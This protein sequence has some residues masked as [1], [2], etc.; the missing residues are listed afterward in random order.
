[1][2]A[3]KPA[4][5]TTSDPTLKPHSRG[6]FRVRDVSI[7]D[8]VLRFRRDSPGFSQR[9]AGTFADRGDTILGRWELC[10][11]EVHWN[12]DLEITYRRGHLLLAVAAELDQTPGKAELAGGNPLEGSD[13]VL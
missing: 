2:P 11:D 13:P 9:F 4:A 5:A 8:D 1:M 10:Q 12:D 3:K 7:D 6:V